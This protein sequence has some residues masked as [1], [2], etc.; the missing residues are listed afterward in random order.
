MIQLVHLYNNLFSFSH[1]T[2]IIP[3]GNITWVNIF[4]ENKFQTVHKRQYLL[5]VQVFRRFL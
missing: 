4:R 1:L 5:P 2:Y 3:R